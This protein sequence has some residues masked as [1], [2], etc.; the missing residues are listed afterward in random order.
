MWIMPPKGKEN[1]MSNYTTQMDAARKCILTK[2]MEIVAK[3][4]L[5][6]EFCFGLPRIVSLLYLLPWIHQVDPNEKATSFLWRRN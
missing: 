6:F 1:Y 2:E 3:K 5:G 4:A